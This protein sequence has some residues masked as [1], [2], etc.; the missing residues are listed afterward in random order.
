MWFW[1]TAAAAAANETRPELIETET[2]II[3]PQM[4]ARSVKHNRKSDEGTSPQKWHVACRE[5]VPPPDGE[6]VTIK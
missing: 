1:Y 4:G 5:V 3:V 6:C 2:A